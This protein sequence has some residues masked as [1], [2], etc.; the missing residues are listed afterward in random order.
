L[1]LRRA[2]SHRPAAN[3]TRVAQRSHWNRY[4]GYR[5]LYVD[6]ILERAPKRATLAVASELA[7]L[8]FVL[9]GCGL[10]G[11]IFAALTVGAFER[12]GLAFWP[13]VFLLCAAADAT[14]ACLAVAG[15]VRAFGDRGRVRSEA[16]AARRP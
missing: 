14:L 1:A 8:S 11:A 13:V 7:R 5:R 15:L 9:F 2:A 16:E 4:F 10:I 6:A 3:R 12:D